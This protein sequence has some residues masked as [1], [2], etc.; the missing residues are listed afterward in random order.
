MSTG[1]WNNQYIRED[2]GTRTKRNRKWKQEKQQT[3]F[4]EK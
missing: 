4:F 2:K 1:K 3:K